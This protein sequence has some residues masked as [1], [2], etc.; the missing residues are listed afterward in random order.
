[1]NVKGLTKINSLLQRLP[2][3]ALYFASWLNENGISH[4]LQQHYRD[5][6]WLTSIAPG[7]MYRTGDKPTLFSALSC[8]NT[9]LNK[10]FYIGALSALEI[11]GFA[12][13]VPLGRQQIMVYCPRGEWFP[14]WFSKYDWGVDIVKKYSELNETGIATINENRFDVAVATP[15]R[16]FLECLSLAPK[17]YYLID[18]YYIMEMLSSLRPDLLQ[19]LLEECNSAKVKRLFLYMAEKAGHTWLE[20]LDLSK[21]NLGTGKRAIVKNGIYNSKYQITLPGDLV[22]YE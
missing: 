12:H 5:A 18:L 3:G 19:N 16:A 22:N 8:F 4:T 15:E 9:Q 2:A 21:I 11:R 6:Q 7:V 14:Q 10:K 13:Y 1:M 17:Y 20:D